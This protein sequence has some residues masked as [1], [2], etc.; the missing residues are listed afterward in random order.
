MR[1]PL[2]TLFLSCFFYGLSAQGIEDLE[3]NTLDVDRKLEQARQENSLDER[4]ALAQQSLAIAKELRYEGGIA[5]ASMLLGEV[6]NQKGLIDEA[7]QHYL[8]A[9]NKFENLRNSKQLLLVEKAIGDLFFNQNLYEPANR[10][11][12]NALKINPQ[13]LDTRLKS[14]DALLYALQ[15][16]SAEAQYKKSTHPIQ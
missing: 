10:Y 7:L 3:Q 9:E 14:A 5:R 13:D 8:L 2:I 1:C 15:F 12:L 4:Y 11:Y 16:D 6:A